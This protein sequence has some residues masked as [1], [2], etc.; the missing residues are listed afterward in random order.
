MDFNLNYRRNRKKATIFAFFLKKNPESQLGGNQPR[1]HLG[2][3]LDVPDL[4]WRRLQRGD[5]CPRVDVEDTD[6]AVERH[7][8][9]EHAGGVGGE[10]DDS[11][12]VAP[13]GVPQGCKVIG[14][15]SA[16][17]LVELAGEEHRRGAVVGGGRP[18]RRPDGLL[19]GAIHTLEPRELHLP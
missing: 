16:D 9:G 14:Q 10:G 8:G 15:P 2:V 5:G 17:G 19:M 6:V 11:E 12:H 3:E 7:C 1:A 4:G 13:R 18:R